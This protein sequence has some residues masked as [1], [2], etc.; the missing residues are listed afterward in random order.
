[1]AFYATAHQTSCRQVFSFK[2][3]T[4]TLSRNNLRLHF[5]ITR[6]KNIGIR[7][8][9][10]CSNCSDRDSIF[11]MLSLG[12]RSRNCQK[13]LHV[14]MCCSRFSEKMTKEEISH[15]PKQFFFCF[16]TPSNGIKR[17][18]KINLKR[19][20]SNRLM[21]CWSDVNRRTE[22]DAGK[23]CKTFNKIIIISITFSSSPFAMPI[24][25]NLTCFLIFYLTAIF[26]F[27]FRRAALAKFANRDLV[28]MI[29]NWFDSIFDHL[30]HGFKSTENA[31]PNQT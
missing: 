12:N 17:E 13:C 15:L 5:I 19:P 3:V 6:F 28:N 4:K 9:T 21:F 26:V 31:S 29:R 22:V 23:N 16:I 11:V 27:L 24:D 2:T 1:M 30:E 8:K 14:F 18:H 10:C 25:F 7:V 20:K